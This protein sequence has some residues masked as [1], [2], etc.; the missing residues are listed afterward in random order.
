MI[1][2]ISVGVIFGIRFFVGGVLILRIFVYKCKMFEWWC[3]I[4]CFFDGFFGS[5][6]C[7][8]LESKLDNVNVGA[9]GGY[10]SR[11]VKVGGVVDLY[12]V[13]CCKRFVVSFGVWYGKMMFVCIDGG[14]VL[15][16][17]SMMFK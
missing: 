7:N 6:V 3:I 2:N 1:F 5:L 17:L 13:K 9:C 8:V 15:R 4:D 10:C 11:R 14:V 12:V 16:S